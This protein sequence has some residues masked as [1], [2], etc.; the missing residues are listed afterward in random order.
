MSSN[1]TYYVDIS[2]E[3]RDLEKYP[4]PADFGITFQTFS[5]TGYFPQGLPL[6]PSGFF[7][8]TSIDPDFI[9][10]GLSFV[11]IEYITLYKR[12]NNSL[13]ISGIYNNVNSTGS[14][15]TYND[16]NIFNL[17]V[18]G[19]NSTGAYTNAPFL[20]RI[21]K[22]E[23]AIPY[24][25]KWQILPIQ[26]NIYVSSS[27]GCNFSITQDNNIYYSFCYDNVFNLCLKNENG[28]IL[29][30][31]PN[32]QQPYG[33]DVPS[34]LPT[35]FTFLLNFDGNLGLYNGRN[36]GYHVV[37][38]KINGMKSIVNPVVDNGKNLYQVV[39]DI[40]SNYTTTL[41]SNLGEGNDYNNQN[42]TLY[43]RNI[44]TYTGINQNIVLYYV[45]LTNYENS[46]PTN[47]MTGTFYVNTDSFTGTNK[48]STDY[49][50]RPSNI[51]QLG[52]ADFCETSTDLYA[53]VN[54]F[55]EYTGTNPGD[56]ATGGIKNP[57]LPIQYYKYDKTGSTFNL[58]D[59]TSVGSY[60]GYMYPHSISYNDNI[61]TFGRASFTGTE[62]S[63]NLYVYKFNTTTNTVSKVATIGFTGSMQSNSKIY[64]MS[65]GTNIYVTCNDYDAFNISNDTIT[66]GY[67]YNFNPSTNSIVAYSTFQALA[68]STTFMTSLIKEDKKYIL[69]SYSSNPDTD[70]YDVTDFSNVSANYFTSFISSAIPVPI[71]YN[72]AGIT[73]Y[74]L[75]STNPSLNNILFNINDL[76]NP[77][78]MI[79]PIGTNY[80]VYAN[81]NGYLYSYQTYIFGGGIFRYVSGDINNG[82][83]GFFPF[84]EKAFTT[85]SIDSIH[86][87]EN[88]SHTQQVQTGSSCIVTFF[89]PYTNKNFL[90]TISDEY[91][92]FYEVFESVDLVLSLSENI[93]LSSIPTVFKTFEFDNKQ[94]FFICYS[95]L[96]NVY[97]ID[98]TTS[99]S[100]TF[101]ETINPADGNILDIQIYNKEGVL[102]TI[103]F[104][105]GS[106]NMYFYEYVSNFTLITTYDYSFGSYG[107]YSSSFYYFDN[108]NSSYNLLIFT[109][110]SLGQTNLYSQ[111]L[112]IT[113]PIN[114]SIF[115]GEE[116]VGASAPP[117]YKAIKTLNY[118]TF[119]YFLGYFANINNPNDSSVASTTDYSIQLFGS[120]SIITAYNMNDYN[121]TYCINAFVKN[122]KI[123]VLTNRSDK[124]NPTEYLTC[125]VNSDPNPIRFAAEAVFYYTVILEAA[126]IDLNIVEIGNKVISISLLSNNN[127]YLYDMTDP[128]FAGQ[129]QERT[130]SQF[131]NY[132]G[133]GFFSN[134][135][136]YEA[137]FIHQI[138]NSGEPRWATFAG[139][140][141]DQLENLGFNDNNTS[142][143][144]L[145]TTITDL[146][147]DSTQQNLYLCGYFNNQIQYFNYTS[148]GYYQTQKILNVNNNLYKDSFTQRIT[149]LTGNSVW[150]IPYFGEEQEIINSLGYS[151]SDN[152]ILVSG[153]SD[154]N[155]FTIYN[156]Q[157]AGTLSN[158]TNIQKNITTISNNS[159]FISKFNSSGILQ[160]NNLIYSEEQ[161]TN[162]QNQKIF[163]DGN[164]IFVLGKSNSNELKTIDSSNSISQTLYSDIN[165][166]IENNL[167]LYVYN[168]NGSY[169][170]SNLVT[171][172]PATNNSFY[173]IDSNR[174]FNEIILLNTLNS[175]LSPSTCYI[176]NKD[177]TLASS[178]EYITGFNTTNLIKYQYDSTYYDN[179]GLPYSQIV[180][181]STTPYTFTG[182][183]FE[184]YYIYIGGSLNSTGI[185][186]SF[187]VRDNFTGTNG[188]PTILLNTYIQISS[189]D[190]FFNSINNIPNSDKYYISN[191]SKSPLASIIEYDIMNVNTGT[192][193]ITVLNS[194]TPINSNQ[195][196]YIVYPYDGETSKIIPVT[197]IQSLPNNEYI[198]TLEYVN[199]L[200]NPTGGNYY[201]P[202]LY[203]ASFNQSLYYNLQY[204]PGSIA[205][206]TYFNIRLQSMT[207]PNRPLLNLSNTYGGTRTLNDIP[208]IYLSI[209]NTDDNDNY[210]TQIVNVVYDSTPLSIKPYPIFQ[211]PVSNQS[212]SNN[213]ATFSSDIQPIV[214]FSP[215][216]YNL[217]IKLFDMKG[218][219]LLFDTS[220][221]KPSDTTFNGGIV[222]DY[223]NNIYFRMAFSKRA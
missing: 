6:S 208:F 159:G 161:T 21:D 24:T 120:S 139:S 174:N 134:N 184:N 41:T 55:T 199:D 60:N 170:Q 91:I 47:A 93:G 168:I 39:D 113:D 166:T 205:Q 203:L 219:P 62:T 164:R 80:Y 211:I 217:R 209:Y 112:D 101:L 214:K 131:K 33:D 8:Q 71:K 84:I 128:E 15:I 18:I 129:S 156:P 67:V 86:Y 52:Y 98:L 49:L 38:D 167:F 77:I 81:S 50:V 36:W 83:S 20:L 146:Q 89:N 202:Y 102:N 44:Y 43:P 193:Q 53:V 143:F 178:Y 65:S 177:G 220:S 46:I 153:Y 185:N 76:S 192:N 162:I 17:Y 213:F 176:Y 200:E 155:V 2:S 132:S 133:T 194:K 117:S 122:D 19:D 110:I 212:S 183:D 96:C 23:N 210:D 69:V 222:P 13:F 136:S 109:S 45:N 150:L 73:N 187:T 119:K 105:D 215:G 118:S 144:L 160:Y 56:Q 165:P 32:I 204:F 30:L 188:N 216:Y 126:M 28:E 99:L 34:Y 148:T 4:N 137:S 201:G 70:F 104:T 108:I 206:P 169:I 103:L 5:E 26:K 130:I 223:L 22:T 85:S 31:I 14:Y 198:F 68:S 107:L 27:D 59:S 145:R 197:N 72:Q 25:V 138:K 9:E 106:S 97:T 152:T 37:S 173:F 57:D 186:R 116:L 114:V 92:N 172:S 191:L 207:I 181:N 182:S 175:Q 121:G 154:S 127:V 88:T 64:A 42:Y 151:S 179:N 142:G 158:P 7:Q 195:F 157:S 79:T 1:T 63:S 74:F 141:V 29:T 48:I 140:T 135:F 54:Y 51:S 123:Y 189:I 12:I 40:P 11:N 87:S 171:L 147:I 196:Y 94:W 221:T 180:F 124:G 61:Y 10:A 3:Y 149:L 111:V 66:N 218:N 78:Q 125:Y 90:S 35:L 16:T 82:D 163:V 75:L 115:A 95:T 190:R 100:L 58:M